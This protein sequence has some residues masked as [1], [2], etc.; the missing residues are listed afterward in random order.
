VGGGST[1]RPHLGLLLLRGVDDGGAADLGQL[2]A[3]AV[4]GPAADLVSDH[5]LDEEDAAVEAEGQPVEQLD[6]LQQVVVGVAVETR[7]RTGSH[8]A[9]RWALEIIGYLGRMLLTWC[10]STCCCFC[11]T[12]ASPQADGEGTNTTYLDPIYLYISFLYYIKYIYIY[13]LYNIFIYINEL[14]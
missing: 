5:V 3:L 9:A 7:R 10:R 4:E 1:T 13:H 2:A 12:P 11:C 6:V 8:A 14:I